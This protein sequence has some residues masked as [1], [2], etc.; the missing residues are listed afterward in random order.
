[1]RWAEAS[2]RLHHRL[3]CQPARKTETAE[4]SQTSRVRPVLGDQRIAI[5][6]EPVEFGWPA[7]LVK[8]PHGVIARDGGAVRPRA[9]HQAVLDVVE[10]GAGAS[11]E[12]YKLKNFPLAKLAT[13]R[14]WQNLPPY[15][16]PHYAHH[17]YAR[18]R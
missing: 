5:P 18:Q 16:Q 8:V 9:L 1:M 4:L 14:L 13:S 17:S 2:A 15:V 7:H 10:V 12:Y 6:V 11:S 3:T